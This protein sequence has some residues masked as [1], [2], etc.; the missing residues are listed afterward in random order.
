M[1]TAYIR[2]YASAAMHGSLQ[3][4]DDGDNGSLADQTVTT[5]SSAASS[6]AFNANTRFICISTPGAQAV[7]VKFGSAP[8]ATTSH[9]RLPA[10]GLYFF[11][12]KP[13]D[14]VSLID[15]D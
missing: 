13:G 1:A 4:P 14:K 8:T 2:E 12:V 10:N 3:C 5:S 7:C 9:L 11:G 6:S 15:V